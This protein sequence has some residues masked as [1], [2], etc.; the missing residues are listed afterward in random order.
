[1]SIEGHVMTLI[2]QVY[3]LLLVVIV[4]KAVTLL[5]VVLGTV[6]WLRRKGHHVRLI[7]NI[8][9]CREGNCLWLG[10]LLCE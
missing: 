1:M 9:I 7:L 4:I 8:R 3:L 5:V 10:L 6:M 2:H